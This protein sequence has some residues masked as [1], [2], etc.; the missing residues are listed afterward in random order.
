MLD[1]RRWVPLLKEGRLVACTCCAVGT[2]VSAQFC[3]LY[4]NLELQPLIDMS[5]ECL[6][7]RVAVA[8]FPL[9]RGFVQTRK[10]DNR[11]TTAVLN[12]DGTAEELSSV[13][14]EA[15]FATL[16]RGQSAS[17][18][19]SPGKSPPKRPRADDDANND[20]HSNARADADADVDDEEPGNP[21]RSCWYLSSSFDSAYH[22][23]DPAGMCYRTTYGL[24]DLQHPGL[25]RL[26]LKRRVPNNGS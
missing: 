23:D 2:T 24:C 12:Q 3:S 1:T 9:V 22:D 6:F 15:K 25:R 19:S 7:A 16:P 14:M 5:K 26:L 17:R 11:S 20:A 13:Q 8:V 21:G 4:H 18:R 10:N